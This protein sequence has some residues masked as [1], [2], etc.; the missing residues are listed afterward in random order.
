MKMPARYAS[1]AAAALLVL[2]CQAAKK[3]MPAPEPMRSPEEILNTVKA[4]LGSA[5]P[6]ARVASVTEVDAENNW[7]AIGAAAAG[8]FPAGEVV[9]VVDEQQNVIGHAT[10]KQSADGKVYAQFFPKEGAR[11][12]RVGDVAV[13]L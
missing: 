7:I 12:V 13:R 4:D 8:D 10:I 2:G 9:S 3:P 5:S 11:K 6:N 1:L